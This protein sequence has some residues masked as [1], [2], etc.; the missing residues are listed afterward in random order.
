MWTWVKVLFLNSHGQI[1]IRGGSNHGSGLGFIRS[2]FPGGGMEGDF[3][4]DGMDQY[5]AHCSLTC[6]SLHIEWLY[7]SIAHGTILFHVI[8]T[9]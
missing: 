8:P 2:I 4:E 3:L 9:H 6:A 5:L 7:I 1:F